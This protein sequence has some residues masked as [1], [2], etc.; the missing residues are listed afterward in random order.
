MIQKKAIRVFIIG[1]Y[2]CCNTGDEAVLAGILESLK[3]T[4]RLFKARVLSADP[5]HTRQTHH[6]KGVKQSLN[7]GG[8]IRILFFE[9][10]GILKSIFWA[11]I[12]LLGGG[13]LIHDLRFYNLPVLLSTCFFAKLLGKK[14]ALYGCGVGPVET[15][16]GKWCCRHLLNKFDLLTVRD[17]R[18]IEWLRDAG[19][20]KRV[21]QTVDPAF[22][23]SDKKSPLSFDQL[24]SKEDIPLDKKFI[25]I[26][27]SGWFR[28]DNFW[29][30]DKLHFSRE[31]KDM[32]KI[33][34][35]T[36][37]KYDKDLIFLT[38]VFPADLK[39][40]LELKQK[41]DFPKRVWVVE[42]EYDPV[43]TANIFKKLDFLIGMR[44]HS[45]IFA[46]MTEVPFCTMVYDQ[47]VKNFLKI[48][49]MSQYSV[50][51]KNFNPENFLEIIEK[52][53][54]NK[55]EIKKNLYNIAQ[56]FK[57]VALENGKLVE[58]LIK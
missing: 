36:I 49:D 22:A 52:T 42:K 14:V 47:K 31:I 51:L 57:G 33:M 30:K 39:M 55:I 48:T 40:A 38:T 24:L 54:Q 10:F 43:S 2:G 27:I 11:K 7:Q 1:F 37:K 29:Q 5:E 21:I 6:I 13:S 53:Y 34:N 58:K 23:L 16:L 44:L 41:C 18:G 8:I 35:E 17:E 20:K 4:G 25:G 9:W 19:V 46:T 50:S 26:T 12:I 28:S 3:K 15:K 56:E 45:L 32:L